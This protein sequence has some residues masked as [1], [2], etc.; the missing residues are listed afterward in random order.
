M[1]FILLKSKSIL[2]NDEK[3]HIRK[4]FYETNSIITESND[5]EWTSTDGKTFFIGKN[6]NIEIYKK[7]NVFNIDINNNLSFI[8]GWLKKEN[9][10]KLLHAFEFDESL[11]NDELDGFFIS[12]FIKSD[13]N[14]EF[15]SSVYYPAIYYI[16]QNEKFAISNRISTL[17]HVFNN[18]TLNKR[19]IASHIEYQHNPLT[20]ET[21]YEN[22]FQIPFGTKIYF[23]DTLT[24]H[25]EHDLFYSESLEKSYKQDSKKYWDE[26]YEKLSSQVLAFINLGIMDNLTMGISGG[27]DSRLIFSLYSDYVHSM[28][29]WGPSFSPEV[30]V[31]HMIAEKFNIEHNL[32]NIN[33]GSTARADNLLEKMPSHIFCCEFEQCPWDLVTFGQKNDKISLSGHEF[34]RTKPFLAKKTIDDILNEERNKYKQ[35]NNYNGFLPINDNIQSQIIYQNEN[36]AREYLSDLHDIQKYPF[37]KRVFNRG[38][39]CSRNHDIT[40]DRSFYICHF[41]SNTVLKYVYNSSVESISRQ[42]IT[43]EI[44]KRAEPSLLEIPF[45]GQS[46]V[47]NPIPPIQNKIPGKLYY[48]NVY[49][50]EY[51]DYIKEFILENFNYIEDIAVKEFILNLTKEQVHADSFISQVLYDLLQSIILIK[52]NDFKDLK[53]SLS[54]GWEISEKEVLNTYNEDCVTAFV[55]YN[56]DIV[57]LKKKVKFLENE[58]E[59]LMNEYD[60]NMNMPTCCPICGNKVDDFSLVENKKDRCPYCK[61]VSRHRL[62]YLFFKKHTSIFEKDSKILYFNP[63]YVL[64][65][66]L[67]TK[68][69]INLITVSF[70]NT[71]L[72]IIDEIVNIESFDYGENNFDLIFIDSKIQDNLDSEKVSQKL[73][74]IIKPYSDGGLLVLRSP[75]Y[76]NL[77]KDA[78]ELAGF[79]IQEY[80]VDNL[81]SLG[82]SKKYNI[83]G[84]LKIIVCKK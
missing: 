24:F 22:I 4:E 33:G 68:E 2:T 48:K 65:T 23:N 70:N 27:L 56:K 77:T 15:F 78:L 10:D 12:A 38:R 3:N 47:Q 67:K 44:M 7:Y 75:A 9:E 25:T 79:K 30:I 81:L 52:T 74:K 19:H 29:T 60:K 40:F 63:E 18:K 71:D 8:H 35:Y 39:W 1:Q 62:F 58:I 69:N 51:F 55:E 73:Y 46:L 37:I 57:H 83:N 82:D 53:N 11:T 14:G 31:G 54:L 61:S 80:G 32:P 36:I 17:A 45:F 84:N 50:V 5:Y 26:C 20:F 21:M 72:N 6:P 59:N 42:D 43:Y 28:F 66:P 41:L 49:L 13:G 16:E 64:Y 34:M 76:N